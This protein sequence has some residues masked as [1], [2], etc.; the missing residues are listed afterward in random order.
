[1]L[2]S[3]DGVDARDIVE[4]DRFEVHQIAGQGT[5]GTVQLGREKTTGEKVAIKR[6]LQDPRFRNR[7]LQIMKD[8]AEMHHPNIVQLISYYYTSHPKVRRDIYLNLVMDFVPHTLHAWCRYCQRRPEKAPPIVVKLFMFQLLRGIACLHL[9]NVNICH[10][11]LKPHNVLIDPSTGLLKVCDFGSA[12]K[13][14]AT[15]VNVSYI[16]SRYYRA[17]E[18]ILGNKTYTTAVDVWSV[19]CIFAEMI[20]GE[21]L[22]R[23][24]NNDDQMRKIMELMDY[25]PMMI[26]RS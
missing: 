25:P 3:N 11:D 22:F 14:S 20:T 5:F 15:E 7:E 26:W 23:G 18:L 6:V 1:M 17:P 13:L 8:L 4:K 21:P 19:G 10:R 24:A 2:D 12:K 9:P 16:C